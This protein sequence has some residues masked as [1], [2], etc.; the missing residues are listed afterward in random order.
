MTLEQEIEKLEE[1]FDKFKKDFDDKWFTVE[2]LKVKTFLDYEQEIKELFGD[3]IKKL[4]SLRRKERFG[5]IP[6][7]YEIS[8]FGDVMSLKKFV[9]CVKS[10]G[11]IDYDGFGR[12][13]KGQ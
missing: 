8:D 12:Y 6:T 11:F 3:K 7:F 10:G 13:I 2:N 4:S 5:R 9:S 1:E